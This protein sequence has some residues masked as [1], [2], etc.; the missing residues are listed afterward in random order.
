[1]PLAIELAAARVEALG[2][3]Q[4]L[5]RLDDRFRLL[6][7][8]NRAAAARQRSLE[9]AVDWSYQLLSGPE[10]HVFRFLSVFPGPFT[11]EAAEAVAGTDAGLAV[12]RLVD[13][14]LLVPPRT[15]P[16]GR[17][18][19]SM[20]ET[21]RGYG[22]GRLR[23]SGEEHAAASALA[24]HA[25]DVAERAAA[26]MAVRDQELPAALWLDA[27]DAA[28]HQGLTWALNHDPPAALRLSLALAP[29]WLVRGRW[30]KGYALLQRA[31]AK[32]GPDAA[33]WY[34]AYVWLGQLARGASNYGIVLGHFSM[35]VDALKDGPPSADLVDGLV[36]RCAALRNMGRLPE[37]AAD[38]STALELARQMGYAAGEAMALQELSSVSMYADHGEDAVE[39]A[40][41][42]QRI[43]RNQMPGW[44]AR[45]VQSVFP[46]ALVFSGHLEGA[47]DLCEQV[48]AQ[49]RA[50]G[51]LS[52]QAD[53]LLMMEVLARET[54]RLADAQVYLN[55]TAKLAV[56]GGYTLRLLD[57]LEEGG[58]LCIATRQYAEAV[59]LW[60][61]RAAQNKA[62]GLV[63]DTPEE[64]HRRE[65]PLQEAKRA[66]GQQQ[67][68]AAEDRGAAMTLAAAVEF[69]VMMTGENVPAPAAASAPGGLSARERELVA[70]VAQGRTDAEIAEQLFIS[71][72]TVSTHLDRIRDKSGCRR[73]ADLTRLALQEG[74]I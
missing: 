21:L 20:L 10:R 28:V 74:I 30:V 2:L 13:C 25:L 3:A 7:N 5:D 58:Y 16:D 50:A 19:Y 38:A 64:E 22:M 46:W 32:T 37:A 43:D 47:L 12:L 57:V 24:V 35:A 4:L 1:M 27:E 67:S 49:A 26:Q 41:Q 9:A 40:R 39:W 68:G 63:V 60:S 17:S 69:A 66:L 42:A 70:L 6:I 65:G 44:R 33:N 29:W 18:R 62:A 31:V 48:L 45:K 56:H 55:E 53:T 51:D 36:G 14:S 59:T 54:G 15:G 34:S 72:S 11:L 23:Q 73:R 61:A 52:G 8:A 71:V